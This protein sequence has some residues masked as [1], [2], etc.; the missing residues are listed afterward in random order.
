[1]SCKAGSWISVFFLAL[2]T[3]FKSAWA[4]P[5]SQS[6]AER[7][8]WGWLK[9]SAQPLGM[10]LAHDIKAVETFNNVAGQPIYH[11][12]SLEPVGFV[13]LSAD[14]QVEPIIAFTALGKFDP[15]PENCLVSFLSE[16]L[17]RRIAIARDLQN[18]R[19][20]A[21]QF[22]N[23]CGSIARIKQAALASQK[24]WEKLESLSTTPTTMYMSNIF[25]VRVVPLVEGQWSQKEVWG[26]YCYNYYTP[27]HYSCGC[28]ATAF[29]Q[30][31]RYHQWPVTGVDSN[32]PY[33]IHVDGA[34]KTAYLR[35]GDGSGGPYNWDDMPLIPDANITE[36]ECQAIGAL[37][38]DAGVANRAYYTPDGTGAVPYHV[39]TDI[40]G[41]SNAVLE[42]FGS[43]PVNIDMLNPNLDADLPLYVCI[44][45]TGGDF[46][47]A[48][49]CDGYGYYGTTLYH[50][51]N[52]GWAGSYNLWYNLPNVGT[53]SG[54]DR[55]HRCFFN[56]YK[57]GTGEII[58][59]RVTEISGMPIDDANVVAIRDGGG[60][61]NSI[62]K[63]NGIYALAKIP[64]DSTYT[65][66]VEKMGHN[67][68][69]RVVSITHSPGSSPTVCG[70]KWGVDFVSVS[71]VGLIDLDKDCYRAPE[72]IAFTLGDSHLQN[73]GSHSISLTTNNGDAETVNLIETFPGSAIF[74]GNIE[75]TEG[76]PQ[77]GDST[78]QVSQWGTIVTVSYEDSNNGTGQSVTV[79]DSAGVFPEPNLLYEANFTGGLPTGWSI[80]DGNGDGN[81]WTSQNPGGR[82]SNCW[83][84]TFMIV[85]SYYA[86]QV[87]MDEQLIT[88]YFDFTSYN[89]V[90]LTFN[91]FFHYWRYELDEIGDVDIRVDDGPWQN[92]ARYQGRDA[93]GPA[94]LDISVFAG[95][96]SNVQIRWRYYNANYEWFWGIDDVKLI[97]L[98]GPPTGAD[99]SGDGNVNFV[100]F[101][102]FAENWMH[103]NCCF[104]DGTELTGDGNVNFYDLLEFAK[105]WL[106]ETAP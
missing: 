48:V 100:D 30:I 9:S 4:V 5:T 51:L 16:D 58:S 49:V 43:Y 19:L 54:Y 99:I 63:S 41:Y 33:E 25:D 8:V 15:S 35:G 104:C 103:T 60:T 88:P 91:H 53:S 1:M 106:Q 52:F 89:H 61:Y 45:S 50:H 17:H 27:N 83:D 101:S 81:T 2:L 97:G 96:R 36:T 38:Y 24:R 68:L 95:G 78:V 37:C 55:I 82:S 26:N 32:V 62:T 102:T 70:N 11:V 74:K 40:F 77:I 85:D 29:A 47:H 76:S 6:Q 65:I 79:T 31:M 86:G 39:L 98:A 56:I 57:T 64:S 93:A 21:G 105:H 71:S 18:G 28:V 59:G 87:D 10:E 34:P 13:I 90:F 75:T 12:V 23:G 80:V 20:T 66:T 46:G 42:Y 44:W 69:P 67:F 84:G 14:D 94:E 72:T 92:V 7:A 73:S 22:K 3:L